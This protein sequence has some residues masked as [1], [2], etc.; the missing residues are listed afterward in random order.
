MWVLKANQP[1]FELVDGPMTGRKFR[2]GE[3]YAEVPEREQHRFERRSEKK[4][5]LVEV[6]ETPAKRGKKEVADAQ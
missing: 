4:T 6:E 3:R 1:S 5:P 2:H